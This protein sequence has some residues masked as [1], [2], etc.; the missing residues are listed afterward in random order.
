[1]QQQQ[2]EQT[3]VMQVGW[4]WMLAISLEYII[5]DAGLAGQ[6]SVL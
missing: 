6:C 5:L 1:M 2:I 3:I 4:G